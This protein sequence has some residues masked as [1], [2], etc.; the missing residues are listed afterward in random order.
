MYEVGTILVICLALG[1]SV[2]IL[3]L[4]AMFVFE[5]YLEFKYKWK[6]HNETRER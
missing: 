5:S 3:T 4:V 1:W 6:L 2:M